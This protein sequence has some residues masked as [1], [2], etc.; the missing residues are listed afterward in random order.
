MILHKR[1]HACAPLCHVKLDGKPVKYFHAVEGPDGFVAY[2]EELP[3]GGG[4]AVRVGRGRVEVELDDRSPPWAKKWFVS[5][6]RDNLQLAFKRPDP[7]PAVGVV[8]PVYTVVNYGIPGDERIKTISTQLMKHPT[9]IGNARVTLVDEGIVLLSVD[10]AP[11][12]R[13]RYIEVA[14]AAFKW[15]L[16]MVRDRFEATVALDTVYNMW[17]SHHEC[18]DDGDEE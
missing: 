11:T 7:V 3:C 6:D 13:A 9:P 2:T 16:A 12:T 5:E 15:D 1:S 17:K 8:M 14:A 4:E 18:D 10:F